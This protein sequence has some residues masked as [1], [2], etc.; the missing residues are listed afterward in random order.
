MLVHLQKTNQTSP[1]QQEM[2]H[3]LTVESDPLERKEKYTKM[4]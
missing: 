3:S 1:G 2:R 4:M